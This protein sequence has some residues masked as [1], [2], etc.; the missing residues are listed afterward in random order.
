MSADSLNLVVNP[1][2][3]ESGNIYIFKK[4]FDSFLCSVGRVYVK[5]DTICQCINESGT[6]FFFGSKNTLPWEAVQMIKSDPS[7][8]L[9]DITGL[10]MQMRR[11]QC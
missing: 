1:H 5:K 11:R 6:L 7:K 3:L 8:Y 2:S 9:D 10:Y 4:D